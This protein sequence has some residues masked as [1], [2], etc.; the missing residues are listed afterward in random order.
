MQ[1]IGGQERHTRGRGTNRKPQ[2]FN[3]P[4]ATTCPL[5]GLETGRERDR[6]CCALAYLTYNNPTAADAE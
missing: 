5:S 6:D 3:G 2:A 4:V 1:V